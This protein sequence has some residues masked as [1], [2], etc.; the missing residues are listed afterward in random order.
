[1]ILMMLL[2]GLVLLAVL[3]SRFGADSRELERA[4]WIAER[5]QPERSPVPAGVV[6]PR[7]EPPSERCP[8]PIPLTI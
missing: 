6:A 2:A 8:R 7:S 5:P 1:M 3:G 4:G